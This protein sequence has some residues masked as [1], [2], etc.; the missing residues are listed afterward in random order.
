[1]TQNANN[2][3][4]NAFQ[5]LARPNANVFE[6]WETDVEICITPKELVNTPTSK[7]NKQSVGSAYCH[8]RRNLTSNGT[9]G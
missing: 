5:F 7:T 2:V 3:K 8:I 1:M 4:E 9:L 6:N